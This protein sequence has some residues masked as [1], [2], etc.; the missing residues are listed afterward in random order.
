[1]T[2]WALMW[3]PGLGLPLLL[4]TTAV[5]GP[6]GDSVLPASGD[7]TLAFVFDVTGSMWDDL[8]QVVEG[9]SRILERSLSGRSKAIANYALVP[10]HDPDIGP[11][12]LTS[13]P[14]VFQR[15]LRELYVQG[16]GDCPEMSIGAIKAAV[17]ISNPSSF[18]YVFSDARAKDYHRKPE[19][20]RLLQL[21]QSQVVFVLTGDCGDRTHPGYLA[22][23]EIAATSSGQVFHLDKQQV[24]E[25]L[26]WVEEAIQVSKVHLLSTDHEKEGEHTWKIPFD[27]SLKEV[28]IS[29]SGP[30][31]EI[32]VRDP[33]GRILQ[34][35][36]GLNMLLNIP[37][38]AKVVAFKPEHPG[39][40]SIKVYSSGRHSVRITGISNINFRAGF[41][42]QPSLDLNHTIEWPLQG[43]PISLVI[44]STGLLA[45]GRLDSVELSHSSGQ[46]LLTLPAGS[47]SNTSSHQLWVG[48]PFRVPK[49]RFYLKVKGEDHEGNPLHRVS[50][51]AYNGVAPGSPLVTMPNKIH[52]YLWQPLLISCSVHSSLPFRLQLRRNGV[53][54]GEERHFQESGNSTWEIP[55]A[56]KSEEGVYE[57]TA[58]SRA[59]TGKAKTQLVVTD[60]PPQLASPQN[61][62]VSPGETALL[63]CQVLDKAPY[64]LTWV[65]DWR[66]LPAS[67][68]RVVQLANLSLEISGIIPSDGGKYQCLASNANGITRASVWLLIREPPQISINTSSRHF[69]Q[70]VELRISCT[71][72]GYPP[73]HI[74]WRHNDQTIGMDG[75]FLVDDQ[76]TLIIQSVTPEDAGNYSCQAT[77]EVGTDEQTVT[78]FY[79]EPPSVSALRPV[80]LAPIGEEAVLECKAS[81]V[82]PPRVIWYRGGLE[83]ILAPEVAH[84]GTLRIQEVQERDAGNYICKA[85][86]ELGA[87]SA[88]IRLEVGYAPRLVESS[89]NMVVEMGRNA[90]LACRAE[91]RPSPRITWARVDGK[92]VPAHPVE[93][94]RARQL[95]A[96]V[97]FL[98][99][100]TPEDQALYICEAHNTFGKAQAEV[101]LTV[102]G[103][104]PPQ[105]ASS[106]SMVR[107]L[108]GQPASLPC[109][110]LAGK[111]F[112]QRHWLKEGQPLPS[113]RY[114]IR[115]DGSF[116]IDR[117]LQEDAGRYS[118]VVTN[119]V[120]SQRQDIELAVQVLPSILPTASHY[121][122]NE[123]V[124]ISLP[125]VSRGIPTPTI[126]W[127]KE[128]NALSPRSSHHQVLK[129]GSLYLPQP[130]AQD[131]GTYVCTAT[132][133]L[134]ISSQEI[135]LSVNTKPRII[136]NESLDSDR[137]VT[138]TALAGKELTL[139]C[140]A[141]GSPSPL[142]TWTKDSQLL[143]PITDR[144]SLLPS[145]SLKLAETSVEDNG[146][147]TCI[148]SNPAG[149]ASRSYVL[150]V[151]VPPQI[152]QGPQ[153]LKVLAGE[154]LDLTCVATGDP[155]P[156]LRWSKD[157]ITLP[158]KG[159]V[160][161]DGSVHLES[162]QVSDSG[163]YHCVASSEAGEDA[164]ELEL[165]VL[166]P[167]RWEA[168]DAEALL[169]RVAGENASLP[170]PVTGTPTPRVI[171]RKDPAPELLSSQPGLSVLN[172]SSLFIASVSSQDSGDYECRATNE[173]GSVSR[174]VKLVVYVPPHFRGEEQRVNVST[175]ASR[176][177]TLN[178]DVSGFPTPA[179]TW[180]KD[181]R[182][183]RTTDIT[184]QMVPHLSISPKSRR[185]TLTSTP[186][187]LD[188]SQPPCCP[189]GR[190]VMSV[191]AF[192]SF[193]PWGSAGIEVAGSLPSQLDGQGLRYSAHRS[194]R[195]LSA[196]LRNGKSW[197]QT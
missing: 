46:P 12:T 59:G 166:E 121:V 44:N 159:W 16:G 119:T 151:Q 196:R 29:L 181:G 112:P 75:R 175:L 34:K 155:K 8:R 23:E 61:V 10:F 91:G 90:I 149:T 80:V 97:L 66:V 142:I 38:S 52:G 134:G 128:T 163:H 147:Y 137:P 127:R 62:T 197:V 73:P 178:C 19:L 60:P 103:H 114:S 1:M 164:R 161:P 180:Y 143:S 118:C 106:A 183:L 136:M 11:V 72:S 88:D 84:T 105:I 24:N 17:E 21:K 47:L 76:G 165:E 120:G 104:E 195:W 140:E 55:R 74:S 101:Q 95:E 20:L 13:D 70:G 194:A 191:T 92:P 54:L 148:A 37:D 113:S 193:L 78:L 32:E 171:W 182:S 58:M 188:L 177:L 35:D 3:L 79:T 152:Q 6:P 186:A 158:Q 107:V 71:A 184:S 153:L 123:G 85:V 124:P 42:T 146:L 172:D 43:V 25:V 129:E 122:T 83:M 14:A 22:Y 96:G 117:A 69:S 168:E 27:P 187:K 145:G 176:P 2:P 93:G 133:A 49:E 9:A 169:E 141:E 82:P 33:L 18:I 98:E 31:P 150:G 7:A 15:E 65:R 192:L 108:E 160:G 48:P 132:N 45:P 110:V 157:G 68:G 40:W 131:S 30:G 116:H 170:C 36:E 77:N 125:C 109:V 87:A 126:T 174:K 154:S 4:V 179:I 89:R 144:H 39:L 64:N 53:K 102:I 156:Q 41:T 94:N 81:G 135:Q 139:H 100:V 190:L 111:P 57:C 99:N 28:T 67:P 51:V 162:V 173:V 167:P 56:S 138:I 185:V 5:G 86:N 63:S 50:N 189:A 26:K 115:T 130:S